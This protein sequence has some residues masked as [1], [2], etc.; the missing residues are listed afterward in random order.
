MATC[1]MKDKC[2]LLCAERQKMQLLNDELMRLREQN[3]DLLEQAK[4]L[5]GA[6]FLASKELADKDEAIRK[7]L[8]M[9]SATID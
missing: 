4:G 9:F 1:G 8:S 5:K 2:G 6:L 7:A 3:T